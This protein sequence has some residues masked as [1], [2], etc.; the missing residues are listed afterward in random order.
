MYATG[1]R[2]QLAFAATLL[3]P[4]MR[5]LPAKAMLQM[6]RFLRHEK[7]TRIGNR[8]V[9]NSFLPPFPG[10][11]F[12]T[13]ARGLRDMLAG[14][15]VPVSTYLSI[16]DKCRYR[17]WHCS[18]A[19]RCTEDMP[20]SLLQRTVGELQ[21][22]GVSIIGLTGGEPLLRE[23]LESIVASI[24]SRSSSILFTSGDG[25]TDERAKRLK[26]S[27]LFGIAVSL[28]HYDAAEHDR[29]RGSQGAFQTALGAVSTAL[30]HGYYTMLQ[31]VATR[32]MF[33]GNTMDRYLSLAGDMGIHEIRLLEPMP[34]G[35]LID[36]QGCCFLS[37]EQREAL[38]A[39]HKRTNTDPG[40]TKISAFAQLEH[41]DMYGCGAGFQHAYIDSVGNVCPCDFVP[42]SFGNVT[43]ESVAPIL[44]RMMSALGQPGRTCLIQKHAKRLRELFKG[45]LPI[46]FEDVEPVLSLQNTGD[47]PDYYKAMGWDAN[48]DPD[49]HGLATSTPC[50][51]A[52]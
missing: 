28:D 34:T 14:D 6:R 4:E 19:H 9:I 25:L 37:C 10:E 17:C 24:D 27:G 21:D 8:Y 51:A 15:P 35:R 31:V 3:S 45:A 43:E 38:R 16:T 23:D 2:R 7:L 36:A 47:L 39:L 5:R 18:K 40:L 1:L 46:R 11:S 30:Q 33:N 44:D 52:T 50:P 29:K 42:I 48:L 12:N 32:D 22:L 26:R 13:L 20:L 49:L 41:G